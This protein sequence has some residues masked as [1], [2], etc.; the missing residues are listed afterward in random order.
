MYEAELAAS[1]GFVTYEADSAA[2]ALRRLGSG[3]RVD[4]LLT[5]IDMPGDLD[6]LALANIVRERWPEI[7][8]VVVS[9]YVD[10]EESDAHPGIAYLRKPFTGDELVAKLLSVV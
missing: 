4:I 3:D 7:K 8:I 10:S 9:S 5:D 2:E 1:A 6:G